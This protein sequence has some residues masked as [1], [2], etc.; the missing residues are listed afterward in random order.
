MASRANLV[1]ERMALVS[2][3][4]L[5]PIKSVML[6]YFASTMDL[7]RVPAECMETVERKR[8]REARNMRSG[9]FVR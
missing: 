6:G 9:E 3:S 4:S 2:R 1:P 7:M 5:E 8:M